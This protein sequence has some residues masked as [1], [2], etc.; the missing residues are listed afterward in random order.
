MS[1][2]PPPHLHLAERAAERLA[3]LGAQAGVLL[4]ETPS[5]AR[6]PARSP[7]APVAPAP[8]HEEV[9]PGERAPDISLAALTRAGLV[10]G[11][12]R[13]SRLSEEFRIVQSQALRNMPAPGADPSL[14][15]NTIMVTSARPGEGKSFTALNLAASIARFSER[16][17][18]LV[19]ADA[20]H[21]ALS[22]P[23]E[24]DDRPGLL[25]LALDPA[26]PVATLALST[27]PSP[28]LLFVPIGA[29]AASRAASYASTPLLPA[30]AA[31]ARHFAHSII[32]IDAPP[33]LASSTAGTLAAQIAQTVIVVE[34]EETQRSEVN[35]ALDM[36]EACRSASLVLNKIRHTNSR[37][38]GAH[39]Y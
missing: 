16:S 24:V 39:E 9:P 31:I 15:A 1:S 23:L 30:I 7:A 26:H 6:S 13:H 4:P 5:L 8:L 33:C 32:V 29:P 25:D 11:M 2:Q 19:D 28:S 3:A 12:A 35:A 36:I 10:A 21:G 14:L 22:R 20:K 34:A 38:F 17:V 27:A 37:S 18:V